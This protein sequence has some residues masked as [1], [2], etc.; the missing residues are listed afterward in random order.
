MIVKVREIQ[1]NK[2]GNTLYTGQTLAADYDVIGCWRDALKQANYTKTMEEVKT[3]N[4]YVAE[5][6][7]LMLKKILFTKM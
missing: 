2:A 6:I 3:F 1:L 7:S 5:L 4:R